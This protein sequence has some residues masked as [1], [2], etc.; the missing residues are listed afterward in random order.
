MAA[1]ILAFAGSTRK[2]SFNK[3]L[4]SIAADGARKVGAEVTA[5]DLAEYPLP[6]F[7]QDLEESNGMPENASKLKQLFVESDGL[8]IASPEYNSSVTGVLKNTIDW[9]SRPTG[10]EEPMAL[11]AFSGKLAMLMAASPGGLGGLRG[12]VH[13]RAIL[14]NLGVTVLPGEVAISKAHEAF[15]EDTLKDDR[16]QQQIREL[17]EKLAKQ[18]EKLLS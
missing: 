15:E 17:G 11:T 1:K 18:A 16:K 12:L 6:L 9:V 4:V 5:I 14:S 10:D 13:L 3:R 8:L 7:N 2:E